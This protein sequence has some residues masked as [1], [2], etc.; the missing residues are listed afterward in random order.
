MSQQRVGEINA[1]INN[2]TEKVMQRF[3]Q[4]NA[5]QLNRKPSPESWS[6]A[7]CID[8]IMV[9][10]KSYYPQYESLISG[11]PIT[12]F[13]KNVPVLPGFFGNLLKK[14]L[15]QEETRKFKTQPAFQPSQS[16]LPGDI[17]NQFAN[18]QY[19]LTKTFNRLAVLD[20]KNEKITSPAANFITYSL[21]D[22]LEIT[23][24]HE[25]RHFLQAERVTVQFGF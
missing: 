17:V 2:V 16:E 8:H 23:V 11:K 3:S 5:E 21:D 22:L 12:N 13:W 25:E 7:Q 14:S 1:R 19:E 4:L 15:R 24:L 9:T 10:N 20:L 18:S 6:I